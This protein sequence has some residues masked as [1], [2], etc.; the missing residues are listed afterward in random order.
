MKGLLAFVAFAVQ[1]AT[2]DGTVIN[3]ATGA[4]VKKARVSARGPQGSY[5]ALSDSS[6]RWSIATI[7]EGEYDVSV[8]CQGFLP[9]ALRRLRVH[10]TEGGPLA[11]AVTPLAVIAGKVV[12]EEGDPVPNV[13]VGALAYDYTRSAPPLQQAAK[14]TTD[15]LGEYR[16]FDLKPGRYYVQA[17]SKERTHALLYH[18]GAMEIGQA[19]P[20]DVLPGAETGGI[21]FRLRKARMFRIRGTLTDAQSGEAFRAVVIAEGPNGAGPR[22]SAQS[23]DG[24]FEFA[25][26]QPGTYRL[27]VTQNRGSRE[28]WGEQVVTVGSRDVE[29][30][31]LTAI[32][33]AD[34]PGMVSVDGAAGRGLN[35]RVTLNPAEQP[36]FSASAL[37]KGDGTF[38]LTAG[39]QAFLVDVTGIPADLYLREIRFGADDASSG[40]IDLRRGAAPLAIV[41]SP[42]P[43][44]LNGTVQL[45]SGKPAGGVMVAIT[46]ADPAMRRRDLTRMTVT[47]ADGE[48]SVGSLAPGEYQVFAW[49]R[50]DTAIAMSFA[51]RRAVGAKATT[52]TLRAGQE[53]SVQLRPIAQADADEARRRIP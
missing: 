6:G 7:P 5:A 42:N 26:V 32:P 18:P 34:I 37:P 21:D 38:L 20:V 14:A 46:P 52:V 27:S 40:G 12:D 2:L 41:L 3:S 35:V 10:G 22:Y 31:A 30:V 33:V 25:A 44:S 43:G 9:P 48:F 23:T 4:V 16:L 29:N 53:A 13:T 24:A 8:E 49:E 39:P 1:A 47:D 19:S 45:V 17:V 28:M 11:L 51:F 50:Y 36:G 15:D